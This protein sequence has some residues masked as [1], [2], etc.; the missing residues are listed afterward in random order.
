MVGTLTCAQ[1]CL[2]YNGVEYCQPGTYSVTE[3]CEIKEF[4]IAQDLA[5]PTVQLGVV[6]TLT[7]ASRGEY[8]QPGTSPRAKPKQGGR[9]LPSQPIFNGVEYCQPGTYS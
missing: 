5:L 4:Q 3:N 1:P 2:T 7:C 8:C 6:G 9:G